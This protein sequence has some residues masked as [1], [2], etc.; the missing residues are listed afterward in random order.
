MQVDLVVPHISNTSHVMVN[1]TCM[2]DSN[3]LELSWTDMTQKLDVDMT[4]TFDKHVK[5]NFSL[6]EINVL[7][8]K[9]GQKMREYD[10][11][12]YGAPW[13]WIEF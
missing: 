12:L 8:T 6:S 11:S 10:H 3:S 4:M 13:T 5:G 7:L 9:T 1:G 2:N